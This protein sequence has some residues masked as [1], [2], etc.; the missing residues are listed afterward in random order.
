MAKSLDFHK[1]TI[2]AFKLTLD[3]K[4]SKEK[5]QHVSIQ[6]AEQFNAVVEKMKIEFPEH[7]SHLP[8]EI[9]WGGANARHFRIADVTFLDFELLLNQ[10]LA[11]LEVLEEDKRLIH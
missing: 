8:R 11:V 6:I 4:S 9:T 1:A 10:V 7:A 5:Q 3:G 2:N